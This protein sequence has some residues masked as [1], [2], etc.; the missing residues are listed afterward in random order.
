M[1]RRQRISFA[2]MLPVPPRP[3]SLTKHSPQLL[4]QRPDGKQGSEAWSQLD[5]HGCGRSSSH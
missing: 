4:L 5:V 3:P 2:V 1:E